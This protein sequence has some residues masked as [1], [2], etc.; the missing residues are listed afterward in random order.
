MRGAWAHPRG[1]GEHPMYSGF[2]RKFEGSSPRVRGTLSWV[3]F[4]GA[5]GGLIPAGAGNMRSRCIRRSWWWAHPRGCGE[6]HLT[7]DSIL[8]LR[9][10]SPRVRGTCSEYCASRATRGLIPAG[11]GNMHVAELEQLEH[12]AHPRG[13][14]EHRCGVH[15]RI[16][17]LGSSPRVRG[18]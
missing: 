14:G 4:G 16:C 12:R 15:S 8:M 1:C 9:G 2:K 3:Y 7:H 18:T 13:C 5:T 11:A 17:E 6:H 10:S